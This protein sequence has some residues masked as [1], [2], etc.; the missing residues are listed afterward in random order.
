VRKALTLAIDRWGSAPALSRIANV[1][2]VGSIIFPG[3]PLAPTKAQIETLPG[4]SPDIA[5]SRAE[6][7]RL[8]KEAGAEGL[9][10]QLLNRDVDQPY[11]F[12]GIWL[13]DQWSKIGVHVTQRVEATGPITA[14]ARSGNYAVLSGASC[15]ATVD[16]IVDV[17]PYL[18]LSLYNANIGFYNDP[19][20]AALYEK[21]L[22]ETSSAKERADVWQFVKWVMGTKVHVA[23]LL[24]WY[25]MVPERSYVH[26]WKISPSHYI[27]QDLST[28]WLAPPHCGRCSAAPTQ[29]AAASMK[30]AARE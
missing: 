27:N 20:E 15:E 4:F 3:S 30:K 9:S 17:Y 18:P 24:W 23:Y 21:M 6:A 14:D 11:K 5:K 19:H 25:R 16:P 8:L 7:R 1:H 28:I 10:F 12:V 2:T 29:A 13:V 22:H 26:G